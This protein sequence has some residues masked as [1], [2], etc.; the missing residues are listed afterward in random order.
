MN[1][2]RRRMFLQSF[3]AGHPSL[4]ARLVKIAG[5][6]QGA[7]RAM[8]AELIGGG[9]SNTHCRSVEVEHDELFLSSSKVASG[10]RSI[11]DL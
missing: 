1:S 6:R 3:C 4:I 2:L 9:R 5:E 10:W 7:A 8:I 11:L